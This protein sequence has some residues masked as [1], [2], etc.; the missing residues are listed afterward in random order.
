MQ[1]ANNNGLKIEIVKEGTG[2]EAQKGQKVEVHYTGMLADGSVFDSS[3]PRGMPFALTLGAGQVIP[4]W[5]EGLLGMKVGEKRRLIIPPEMAYGKE[6]FP[7]AI[8]PNATLTF[9]V[10]LIALK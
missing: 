5:E 7:G 4:G 3:I 2:P 6:G 9:D 10:E 1:T 8:P